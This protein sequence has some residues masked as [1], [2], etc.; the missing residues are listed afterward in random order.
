MAVASATGMRCSANAISRDIS[1]RQ[2]PRSRTNPVR[3]VRT[4][5]RP[6]TGTA[7]ATIK[8]RCTM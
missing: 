8:L 7:T 4:N 5:C 1:A 3:R 2:P 6:T